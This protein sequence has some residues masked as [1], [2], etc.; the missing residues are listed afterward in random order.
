MNRKLPIVL[1]V[2]ALV[3][4]SSFC[5]LGVNATAVNPTTN[6]VQN[7]VNAI[8]DRSYVRVNGVISQWGTTTVNG[9]IQSQARNG[10]FQNGNSNQMASATATWTTNI[11]RPI[12]YI[13]SKENFTYVF[14][15]ARLRNASVSTL[16]TN[17]I[18]SNYF[19]S[20]TWNLF[21][22]T[23]NVTVITNSLG[24][25]TSV[26]R[27]IDT[28][29]QK[30]FGE[31]TVTDNWTKFTLA[32]NG[33]DSLSGSVFRSVQRQ[34]QFNPFK[35]TDDTTTNVVTKADIAAVAK[36]YGAIPGWGNYDARMDFA[37][38]FKI[39]IA[40]LSTVACKL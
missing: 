24:Q 1:A 11:S 28:S 20:G 29:V 4:L 35:V 10:V 16:S 5:F 25:I 12:T 19:L 33:I 18:A 2:I 7:T 39:D 8:L 13:R 31:L 32:I 37:G 36:A 23:S 40:A 3:A 21:T 14:Y 15:E 9:A 27:S 22:V 34:V 6:S 17:S 38:H 30:A 26:H